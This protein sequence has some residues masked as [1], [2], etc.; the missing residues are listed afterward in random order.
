MGVVGV[1]ECAEEG[2]PLLA[3]RV[4]GAILMDTHIGRNERLA[5]GRTNQWQFL[6]YVPFRG[7]RQVRSIAEEMGGRN[8]KQ[9]VQIPW[10]VYR[11]V[12]VGKWVGISER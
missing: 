8:G 11:D 3:T 10:M 1:S 5:L 9:G 7:R 6:E 12:Q 2:R 4:W